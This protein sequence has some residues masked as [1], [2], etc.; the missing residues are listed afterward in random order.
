LAVAATESSSSDDGEGDIV[1]GAPGYEQVVVRKF[2]T[3][4]TH[5]LLGF[6]R[7]GNAQS[8][9]QCV[10]LFGYTSLLFLL[11]PELFVLICC[12]LAH[13]W[14]SR[15]LVKG[16]WVAS[17]ILSGTVATV[18][19]ENQSRRVHRRSRPRQLCSNGAV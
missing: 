19:S 15:L 12:C 14:H 8:F 13:P 3:L 18:K 17:R 7:E 10:V 1:H 5:D 9:S 11:G 6:Q 2:D 16:G 4:F